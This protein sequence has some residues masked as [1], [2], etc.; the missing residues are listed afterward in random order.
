MKGIIF[1]I[2]NNLANPNSR[3]WFNKEINKKNDEIHQTTFSN[4]IDYSKEKIE[5]ISKPLKEIFWNIKILQIIFII[6]TIFLQKALKK[7]LKYVKI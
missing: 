3:F 6:E 7:F 5:N 1:L 4:K 2:V